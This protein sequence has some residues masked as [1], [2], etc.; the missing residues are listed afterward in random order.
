M[1]TRIAI[2]GAGVMGKD[3][4][5]IVVEDLPGAT[6]Q[7]VCDLDAERARLVADSLGAADASTDALAVIG[8]R[9]VDAVIV[10]SPDST[11]ASLSK[12]CVSAGKYVLCEK[13]LSQSSA[14]CLDVMETE[15]TAGRKFILLGFMRRYDRTYT[16]MRMA[17][18]N[19]TIGRALMMHNFH[20]NVAIP[21]SDFTSMM[22]ITNSAPHEFD[23]VRYVLGSECSSI[24]AFRPRR[25]D[26][27]VAP[28]FLVVETDTGQIATIEINNSAGYGYDVRAELVGEKGSVAS[29]DL[30]YT[31]TNLNLSS[32]TRYDSDW[33]SRYAE[34]YRC[35]DQAFLKFV[36]TGQFPELGSNCWD[37]Y[38]TAV[39]AE[40]GVKSLKAGQKVSIE[41]IARPEFYS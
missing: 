17:L 26:A 18:N 4:A 3:H 16:E 38:C 40:A 30:A 23:I 8:R 25:S 15:K 22:A 10:A 35:Q 2:I 20:R 13:P 29:N 6:L 32:R 19:G 5:K 24:S 39:I 1:V 27:V 9:D 33:R 7:V 34:A 12:A 36:E 28:V 21:T 14:E 31:R 37:G 41:L 11:H